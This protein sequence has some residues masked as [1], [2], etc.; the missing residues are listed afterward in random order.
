MDEG[1]DPEDPL[2]Q[3][4]DFIF[5]ICIAPFPPGG[6]GGGG[7]GF[8]GN[9]FAPPQRV[10][11][12]WLDNETSGLPQGLNT[13]PLGMD[14]L[15]GLL[16][17]AD[18]SAFDFTKS[19]Q[20]PC[21]GKKKTF[22]QKVWDALMNP[23]SSPDNP[24]IPCGQCR[25]QIGPVDLCSAHNELFVYGWSCEGGDFSIPCC[26]EKL[27]AFASGCTAKNKGNIYGGKYVVEQSDGLP[28]LA[29]C[30]IKR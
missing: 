2:C 25:D 7:G 6:G 20:S 15:L 13:S 22:W 16:P 14:D 11:G 27:A 23:P 5:I 29:S 4:C 26:K 9:P 10:G 1:C 12:V 3:P 21:T 28:M 19:T 18:C 30:C 24:D 17:V 8:G